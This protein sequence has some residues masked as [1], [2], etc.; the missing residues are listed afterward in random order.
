MDETKFREIAQEVYDQNQAK[1]QNTTFVVPKHI[2]NGVDAPRV[3]QDNID[4]GTFSMCGLESVS[5]E[6]FT[7]ETFPNVT[8]ISL[9]GIAADN[10]GRKATLQGSAFIGN[11]FAY[12]NQGGTNVSYISLTGGQYSTIIQTCSSTYFDT[13]VAFGS[14]A[15]G[16]NASGSIGTGIDEYLIYV[17]DRTSPT[18]IVVAAMK[19]ISWTNNTITFQTTLA[20]NWYVKF[21]LSMS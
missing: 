11:C 4:T 19:I 8:N 13:T 10:L 3:N 6:T 21:F 15:V 16:V 14:T 20:T 5:S 2:H 1:N 18:P 17:N 7:I 12:G 9:Y